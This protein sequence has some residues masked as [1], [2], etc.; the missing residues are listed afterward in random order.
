MMTEQDLSGTIKWEKLLN[1]M[2]LNAGRKRQSKQTG[3]LHLYYHHMDEEAHQTIPIVENFYFILALLRTKTIENINE[4]KEMLDRLLFFQHPTTGN[5]PTYLHEYPH[6]K[7]QF[8]GVQLLPVFFYILEE[9]H[10]ILG[11]ELLKRIHT[12]VLKFMDSVTSYVDEKAPPYPIGIKIAAAAKAFGAYFHDQ[13]LQE[14]GEE[15]LAQFLDNGI[16]PAWFI[17]TSI[18]DICI[19]LQMAY[20]HIELSPWKIF[21]EHLIQTW[22]QPTRTYIGPALK[23]YQEEDEPQS[24]LYDLFLSYFNLQTFVQTDQMTQNDLLSPVAAVS[25]FNQ[26][27]SERALKDAPY[28]LQAVLI[29]P[30]GEYFS[31]IAASHLYQGQL[32]NSSWMVYQEKTYAYHLI[33]MSALPNVA[34]KNAFHP[35]RIIWGSREKVYSFVCQSGNFDILTF[36]PKEKGIELTFQLAAQ[37]ELEDREKSRELAFFFTMDP[38]AKITFHEELA[39]TFTVHDE[40]VIKTSQM[41]L[42]LKISLEAG[43]GDFIGHLMKGN[44]PSQN[45][46]KGSNRFKAYDWQLF[47]RTLR[48]SG[49]CQLKAFLQIL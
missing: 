48:R 22:H 25:R 14:K 6:C 18:A 31:S 11:A 10:L 21:R 5:F 3:Y 34:C 8:L 45:L 44:R 2:A 40:C 29:R 16:H 1:E 30:T 15:L 23:L 46:L 38:E 49:P 43:E 24:T 37:T 28:H 20:H 35:L 19:A 26:G 39:T 42:S 17:P 7:D 4:A 47:L 33:E 12:A 27:F 32:Q 13:P 36:N 41:K 9:F